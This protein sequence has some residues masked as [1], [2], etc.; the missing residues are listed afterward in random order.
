M[1]TSVKQAH[2]HL[3]GGS[4]SRTLETSILEHTAYELWVTVLTGIKTPA[5]NRCPERSGEKEP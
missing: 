1:I 3:F 2:V 4:K 5:K